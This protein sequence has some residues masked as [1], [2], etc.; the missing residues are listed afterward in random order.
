MLLY[1]LNGI[2]LYKSFNNKSQDNEGGNLRTY[3]P[4]KWKKQKMYQYLRVYQ[5]HLGNQ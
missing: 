1:T 4:Q 5:I 2:E 3:P